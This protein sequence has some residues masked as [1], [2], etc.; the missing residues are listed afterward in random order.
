MSVS[1]SHSNICSESM[2]LQEIYTNRDLLTLDYDTLCLYSFDSS[3]LS[4]EPPSS[5]S[6]HT[7]SLTSDI[8]WVSNSW[9][10]TLLC[11]PDSWLQ[12]LIIYS[13]HHFITMTPASTCLWWDLGYNLAWAKLLWTE[14][15]TLV[16]TVAWWINW[17]LG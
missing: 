3:L 10:E 11:F 2:S 9:W 6:Q 17:C 7:S 15:S 13:F 12:S 14:D 8:L 4:H 1:T 5:H 16:Q